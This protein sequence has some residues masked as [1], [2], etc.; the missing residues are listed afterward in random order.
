LFAVVFSGND[1]GVSNQ[2]AFA[3]GTATARSG[4]PTNLFKGDVGRRVVGFAR[5]PSG[6]ALLMGVD[7]GTTP[8]AMLVLLDHGGRRASAGLKLLGTVDGTS[9]SV[10]GTEI[11]VLAR[12]KEGQGA[13]AL[14]AVEFRPFDASGAPLG[15]WVCFEPPGAD[16]D[17]GGAIA[18]E[19]T[20]YAAVFRTRD[21]NTSLAR[22]D[23][24]GTG[25]L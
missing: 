8:Y 15:P 4:D 3:R 18:A 11:G 14:F 19:G 5:T 16:V 22:F 6:Y 10:S 23:R 1:T 9:L 17:F 24:L 7:D 2:T 12:R 13:N 25:S 20:G 21:G